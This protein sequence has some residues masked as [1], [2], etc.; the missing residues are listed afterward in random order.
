MLTDEE[1]DHIGRMTRA[2]QIIVAA[3][4]C[5]VMSFL[6]V[7][8]FV[9]PA[10]APGDRLLTYISAFVGFLAPVTATFV[11]RLI[12]SIQ[13]EAIAA[14]RATASNAPYISESLRE[15]TA[16]VG[17]YQ[18]RLIVRCALI[19]GAAF[20]AIVA[21]LIER[22]VLSLAVAGALLLA[23]LSCFPTRWK[24]EEAVENERREIEQLRQL[25]A[26]D[27]R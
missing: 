2:M 17:G 8:L 1:R 26:A 23:M 11:P 6:G 14:Q 4:A 27:A 19:E 9:I 22:Q 15:M 13:R 7:V 25:G 18:T 21:F 16:L 24:V 20:F 3:L 12:E 10:A 5:G